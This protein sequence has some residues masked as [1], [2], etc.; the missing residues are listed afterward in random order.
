MIAD[1][2]SYIVV[3]GIFKICFFWKKYRNARFGSGSE[4]IHLAKLIII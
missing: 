1:F 4:V 2:I 3:K